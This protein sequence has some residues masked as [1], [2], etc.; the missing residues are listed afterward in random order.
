M[1]LKMLKKSWTKVVEVIEVSQ[2][3]PWVGIPVEEVVV[4][5]G[6]TKKT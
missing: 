6:V 1:T 2:E 3:T 5:E 4:E